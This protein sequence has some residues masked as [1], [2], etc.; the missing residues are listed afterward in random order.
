MIGQAAPR[1]HRPDAEGY[2]TTPEEGRD[3]DSPPLDED[4]QDDQEG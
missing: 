4:R 3:D 2:V 1:F